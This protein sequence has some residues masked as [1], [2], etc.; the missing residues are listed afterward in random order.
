MSG[1]SKL[2]AVN[3]MLSNIGESPASTLTGASGDA[4]VA[5]AITILDETVRAVL[6]GDWEFNQDEDYVLTPNGSGNIVVTTDMLSVDTSS[7]S[8]S[9]NVVTR[10]GKLYD[11]T[12]Q[13]FVFSDSLYC[14]VK[15]EFTYEELPQ[16]MRQYIAVKAARV[17]ARRIL[18]DT[19]GEQLTEQDESDARAQAK[20]ND[21][22][23]GDRNIMQGA[24]HGPGAG[25]SRMQLRRV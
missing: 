12:N 15:W 17:F 22:K 1:Q 11:K 21:I 3:L 18:G 8:A 13:T 2:E 7:R 10:A 24:Q 14:D 4:F 25:I 9:V 20:R 23:V 5:T 6:I 19:T 16:Y